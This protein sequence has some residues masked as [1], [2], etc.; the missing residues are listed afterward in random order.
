MTL[1]SEAHFGVYSPAAIGWSGPN[2]PEAHPALLVPFA[3]AG[4][5]FGSMHR[6]VVGLFTALLDELVPHI[7]GGLVAGTCGCYNPGSVTVGGDRSFHTYGIA[8]DVNW[9]ANPMYAKNRPTG[10]HALPPVTSQIARSFGCEWGGDWTYPQDWM[11]IEVHLPPDVAHGVNPGHTPATLASTQLLHGRNTM[12]SLYHDSST[13]HWYLG[14][15]GYFVACATRRDVLVAAYN[16]LCV[17]GKDVLAAVNGK[18]NAAKAAA[19][20]VSFATKT[21]A[22]MKTQLLAIGGAK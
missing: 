18:G 6:D 17:N 21:L 2:D 19:G 16:P 11:H 20:R 1:A 10:A 22:D 4:V 3:Y 5:S 9:N 15:P 7:D 13:G 14:A 12:F 8:I